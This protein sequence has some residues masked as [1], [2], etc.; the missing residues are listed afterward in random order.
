MSYLDNY[1]VGGQC[2]NGHPPDTNGDVGINYY[3][4]GIN[5]A[6]AI[7]DKATGN[8]LAAF[9]E[10]SLWAGAG[11]TPC[12]TDPFGDPIVLYDQ[13]AD[14]WILTNLGFNLVNGNP[15]APYMQC[16]AVSKTNDPVAGG[17]WLYAIRIDQSPVPTNTRSSFGRS[18]EF[19]MRKVCFV[20]QG[21]ETSL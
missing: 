13:T 12:T 10:V 18:G 1:C 8:R 20:G 3:I 6:Y 17:Y 7:Y 5:E 15:V 11:S 9:T 16:F 2:G 19:F 4:K 14:R 21:A